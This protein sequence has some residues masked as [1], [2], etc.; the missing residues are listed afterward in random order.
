MP[1]SPCPARDVGVRE[2]G[3]V[4]AFRPIKPTLWLTVSLL[5]L[6]GMRDKQ[7]F[8]LIVQSNHQDKVSG[9]PLSR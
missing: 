1:K 5:A 8:N 6:L 4:A 2:A 9:S 3:A 7:T